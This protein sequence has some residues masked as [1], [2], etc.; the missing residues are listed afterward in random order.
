MVQSAF[1]VRYDG[2]GVEDG[3][4]PVRD[5]APALLALGELF[6][7]ASVVLYPDREPVAL[8]IR[9]TER[10]SFV[11]DLIVQSNWDQFINIFGSQAAD[12]IAHFQELI[13]G[14][15]GLFAFIKNL[16]NRQVTKS[17]G[18]NLPGHVRLTLEDGTTLEVPTE[19]VALHGRLA[20]RK[21]V[22]EVITPLDRPGV[23]RVGFEIDREVTVEIESGDLPA[24][25]PPESTDESLGEYETEMVVSIASVAFTDNKWRL[26]DGTSTFYAAMEDGDFQAR[27]DAGEAFRK[28]DM[29]RCRMRVE[30]Y[31]N[32][33]GQ[34]RDDHVVTHVVEHIPRSPQMQLGD[35]TDSA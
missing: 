26:R 9:A 4:M 35:G 19:V 2:P 10:G 29:L 34:L 21:R 31:R 11:V 14:G 6:A 25:E 28:G 23:D 18:S 30:Q 15:V 17:E 12:A 33:D 1:G 7:E 16:R 24:F 32:E 8:D 3:R 22:R 13:V 5:L 27:M 20:V